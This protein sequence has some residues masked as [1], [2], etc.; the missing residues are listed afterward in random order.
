MVIDPA[1][2]IKRTRHG[3]PTFGDADVDP[4]RFDD[5]GDAKGLVMLSSSPLT[6]GI[7]M[8]NPSASPGGGKV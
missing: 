8:R 4:A 7:A 3:R 6:G 5:A 2:P 1:N